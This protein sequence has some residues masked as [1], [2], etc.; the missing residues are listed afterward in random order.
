MT[1]VST[2]LD[3]S[4]DEVQ[5]QIAKSLIMEKVTKMMKVRRLK[6]VRWGLRA[7]RG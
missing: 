3:S 1:T 7:P 5:E 6:R 2:F 4:S